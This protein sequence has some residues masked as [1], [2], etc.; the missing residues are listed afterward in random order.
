[1]SKL[2]ERA[3]IAPFLR[4]FPAVLAISLILAACSGAA[5]PTPVPPTPAP[6]P[7]AT[8]APTATSAPTATATTAPTATAVPRYHG[9]LGA[10]VVTEWN[11]VAETAAVDAVTMALMHIAIHD[12]LNSIDSRYEP[13]VVETSQPGASP[14]AAV[15]SAAHTLLFARLPA[16]A[17]PSLAAAL[18]SSLATIPDGT[19]KTQGIQFGKAVGQT[20]FAFYNPTA[21][22]GLP[23]P[24]PGPGVWSA[25][26]GTT[27][28]SGS[29]PPKFP[30]LTFTNVEQFR[31]PPPVALTSAEY[32]ADFNE[33]KTLGNVNSTVRTTEQTAIANFWMPTN[34]HLYFSQAA[35]PLSVTQQLDLWDAARLFAVF[36]IVAAD[37]NRA[38]FDTK[39]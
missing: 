26:A 15:A 35:R 32:A 20:V 4:T 33:S 6:A 25:P 24:P 31:A 3:I 27:T 11:A 34:F 29:F 23:P 39:A 1:M 38:L 28:L 17:R 12:A 19:A 7:T 8:R 2:G 9:A 5:T 36:T 22:P 13:F 16:A 18:A 21:P 30:A 37:E 14:E 10:N